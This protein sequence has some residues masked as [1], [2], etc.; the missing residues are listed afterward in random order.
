MEHQITSKSG[1]SEGTAVAVKN[2]EVSHVASI[3]DLRGRVGRCD[4]AI[5]KLSGDVKVCF[6]TI[7]SISQQEQEKHQRVIN[8]LATFEAMVSV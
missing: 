3:T 6:E 7:K 5:A 4:A 2:L 1:V 8:K